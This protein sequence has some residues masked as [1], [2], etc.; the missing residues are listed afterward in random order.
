MMPGYAGK[1]LFVDLTQG[2]VSEEP[3]TDELV[4][5]FIGGYGMGAKVL[6]D[7][8]P[9]H[10]DPMG[11]DNILGFV[12]GPVTGSKALFGGRYMIVHKSPDRKSVV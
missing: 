6:Y 12:T 8:M 4:K 1:M 2:S 7:R 3:L 5:T 9:A 10:A 11:P